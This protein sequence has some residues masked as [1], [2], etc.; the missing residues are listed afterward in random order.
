M[1]AAGDIAGDRDVVGLIRE[2][3]PCHVA[4]HEAVHGGDVPRV[5]ADHA[6]ITE[7]KN[8]AWLRR[9]WSWWGLDAP[10]FGHHLFDFS[11]DAI[12]LNE[13]KAGDFDRRVFED[14]FLEL[15]LK[16]VEAPGVL[17]TKA[18]D[19]DA[20]ELELGSG[21]RVDDDAGDHRQIEK[22]GGFDAHDAVDHQAV[23]ID[24]YG[25]VKAQRRDRIYDFP[26][27]SC[28]KTA[29]V[30]GRRGERKRI[31]LNQ[32]QRRENVIPDMRLYRRG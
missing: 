1:V 3:E 12:D 16:L 29:H 30:A 25:D 13:I 18:I 32:R 24:K 26:D 22:L 21:E 19:R 7:D 4:T 15:Q 31:A 23:A 17:L 2:D 8:V 20:K 11:E 28:I 9:A 27:V 14:H 6:V 5:T 10:R